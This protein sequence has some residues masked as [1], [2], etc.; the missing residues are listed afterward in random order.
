VRDSWD[1]EEPN[2]SGSDGLWFHGSDGAHQFVSVRL[3]RGWV[4]SS[5]GG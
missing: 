3:D 4:K 5:V 2:N 1:A